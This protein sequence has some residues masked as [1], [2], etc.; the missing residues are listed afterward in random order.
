[1]WFWQ[2]KS[3]RKQILFWTQLSLISL[4]LH[5]GCLWALFFMYGDQSSILHFVISAARSK[6]IQY[7]VYIEKIASAVDTEVQ[8]HQ[9]DSSVSA[10]V[11]NVLQQSHKVPEIAQEQPKKTAQKQVQRQSKPKEQNS[12]IVQPISVAHQDFYE[13]LSQQWSPPPG[14]P[15]GTNCELLVNIDTRGMIHEVTVSKSSNILLF[16]IAAQSVM[17]ESKCPRWTWGK[18]IA[19][20]FSSEYA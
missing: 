20:T 9:I 18:T 7:S 13:N 3:T 6:D 19:V 15:D 11:A 1:M 16:D 4:A 10:A 12:K 17:H 14:I 8:P 5:L 2:R